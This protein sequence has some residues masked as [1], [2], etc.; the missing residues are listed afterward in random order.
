MF[1]GINS[2]ANF[3]RCR[4]S[5]KLASNSNWGKPIEELGTHANL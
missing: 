3:N 2:E 5:E 1:L 4:I